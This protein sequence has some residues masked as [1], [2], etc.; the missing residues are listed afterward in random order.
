VLYSRKVKLSK[1]KKNT[2]NGKNKECGKTKGMNLNID[3][4]NAGSWIRSHGDRFR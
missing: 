2:T 4:I 1:K 3:I